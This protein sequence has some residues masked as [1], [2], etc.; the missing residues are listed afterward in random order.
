MAAEALVSVVA[1][2]QHVLL[3]PYCDDALKGQRDPVRHAEGAAGCQFAMNVGA[4]L[5][6][7]EVVAVVAPLVET[8]VVGHVEEAVLTD[9]VVVE[10]V[11]L[12]STV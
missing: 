5:P 8:D 1:S 7:V 11:V 3:L 9:A 6:V 10:P 4:V 2:G 12:P